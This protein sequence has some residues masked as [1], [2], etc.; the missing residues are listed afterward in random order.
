[1]D[2][3]Q[4]AERLR[5]VYEGYRR[6]Q[7][8]RAKWSG[9]N[10]GNVA[11]RAELFDALLDCAGDRLGA[12]QML[13][14]G[15]GSAWLLERLARRGV[16]EDR[17][18]GVDL[19]VER[20]DLAR[21]RVPTADIRRADARSLPFADGTFAVVSLLAVLS[22]MSE[23]RSVREALR[24]AARVTSPQ[25]VL[26]CY[27]A[28][29]PNPLNAET[30]YVGARSIEAELGDPTSCRRVTGLPAVARR[31]GRLTPMLYGSLARVAPT[32]RVLCFQPG[33]RSA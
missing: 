16:S 4:D 3:E 5:R 1:M 11:I 33:E 27:E 7:R 9:S 21:R 15:C 25:G 13:D 12:G 29:L 18:C 14:I 2:T 30:I 28:S 23:G 8:K 20:V 19:L 17:L 24:E 26:V 32:H 31:L 10:P 6:D 22:S